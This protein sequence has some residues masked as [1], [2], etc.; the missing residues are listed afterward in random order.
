MRAFPRW[1]P[2]S[3]ES[4]TLLDIV[5]GLLPYL[6]LISAFPNLLTVP[7]TSLPSH[8]RRWP[9]LLNDKAN[10]P[11]CPCISILTYILTHFSSSPNTAKA[12]GNLSSLCIC[13][14]APSPRSYRWDFAFPFFSYVDLSFS[15][16]FFSKG[17][18]QTKSFHLIKHSFF[19][20]RLRATLSPFL[21]MTALIRLFGLF[22]S[23]LPEP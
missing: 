14:F 11:S 6:F 3:A 18:K 20:Q 17:H 23:V 4:S 1:S 5:P 15:Y 10:L 21:F 7:N 19:T 8:L 16:D 2:I 22:R 13:A 9:C 12:M